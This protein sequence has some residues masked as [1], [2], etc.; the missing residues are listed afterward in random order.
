[1][2]CLCPPRLT[3]HF[4]FPLEYVYI[5]LTN[6]Y[7]TFF[8]YQLIILWII[9][10]NWHRWLLVNN[11]ISKYNSFILILYRRY[12]N[13]VSVCPPPPPLVVVVVV[14][15]VVVVHNEP[16][17]TFHLTTLVAFG[18]LLSTLT[19]H[20]PPHPYTHP[21]PP[22][23]T[24]THRNGFSRYVT[25]IVSTLKSGRIY[26]GFMHV[27]YVMLLM[28]VFYPP[29]TPPPPPSAISQMD[30]QTNLV[31]ILQERHVLW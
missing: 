20:T 22:T 29:P 12:I 7:L 28:T 4:Y 16:P 5:T 27:Q 17:P 26:L 2:V 14:G 24:H 3:P 15:L 9:S 8:I 21:P 6:N 25:V 19:T 1:M 13:Y 30:R 11:H 18:R 23:P 10:I 31:L